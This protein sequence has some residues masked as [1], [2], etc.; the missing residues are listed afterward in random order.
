MCG[1]ERTG[2]APAPGQEGGAQRGAASG[3]RLPVRRWCRA[4]RA[5]GGACALACALAAS[6]AASL[7]ACDRAQRAPAPGAPPPSDTP[8]RTEPPAQRPP[9]RPQ[10]PPVATAPPRSAQPPENTDRPLALAP[11]ALLMPVPGIDPATLRDNYHQRRGDAPHHAL[12][13]MAPRGTPVVAVADGRIAK[14]FTSKP[15]GL[16]VYQFDTSGRFAYYYAHLDRYAEGLA[17]GQLLRRGDPVGTVGST[18]NASA[19]APHLHFAV[20][21]LGPERAWWKGTPVNPFPLIRGTSGAQPS[22]AQAAGR[23]NDAPVGR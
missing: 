22:G 16:T 23:S 15:G 21:V 8:A 3:L 13:I 11:G 2:R 1:P 20:H 10:P 12:D 4:V 19:D 6:L 5:R 7:A 17:E 9:P 18:G 14:L